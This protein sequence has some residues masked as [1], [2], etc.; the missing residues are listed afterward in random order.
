MGVDFRSAAQLTSS[1]MSPIPWCHSSDTRASEQV[2][3]RRY[4][5]VSL[6]AGERDV[7]HTGQFGVPTV[8]I[9]SMPGQYA[10]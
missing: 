7:R 6:P 9:S 10:D 1:S 8:S 5:L 4:G 3:Q 2:A